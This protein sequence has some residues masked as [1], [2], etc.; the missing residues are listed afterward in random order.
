MN[1][2]VYDV[3]VYM[4][5]NLSIVSQNRSVV[6]LNLIVIYIYFLIILENYAI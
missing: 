1:F 4:R 3:L 2:D 5:E 6:C